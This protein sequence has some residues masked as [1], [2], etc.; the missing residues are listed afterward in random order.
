MFI[1]AFPV[2]IVLAWCKLAYVETTFFPFVVLTVKLIGITPGRAD[3]SN[4]FTI[5]V[6]A[7]YFV[8]WRSKL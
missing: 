7:Q 8:N 6:A 2:L 1:A 5:T 3:G 4:L